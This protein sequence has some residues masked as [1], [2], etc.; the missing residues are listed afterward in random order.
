MKQL[1]TFFFLFSLIYNAIAAD[2][3]WRGGTG[4][5]NDLSMWEINV[6]GSGITPLN[7]PLS[8]DDVYFPASAFT[9]PNDT[10]YVNGPSN[11]HNMTWDAAIPSANAPVFIDV[12]TTPEG[13]T[14]LDIYGSLRLT[15]NMN[16]K[17]RGVLR[18]RSIASS[19]TIETK[20]HQFLL[21]RV[22]FDGG[23]TTEWILQDNFYLDDIHQS[24]TNWGWYWP[25][26]QGEVVL[27]R[28]IWNT[29]GMNVRLD[30]FYS[31]FSNADRGLNIQNSYIGLHG[32]SAGA[33]R[34]WEINFDYDL[35]N[36]SLFEASGS[37]LFFDQTNGAGQNITLGGGLA[38]DSLSS[39]NNVRLS[40][41][42]RQD[43]FS[44]MNVPYRTVFYLN[45]EVVDMH[46]TPGSIYQF[47]NALNRGKL[48]VTNLHLPTVCDKFTRVEGSDNYRGLI[49][50]K[51]PG[52]LTLNNCLMT[53]MDCDTVGGRNYIANNSIDQGA[54]HVGWVFNVLLGKSM[55]FRDYSGDQNWHNPN[56][57]ELWDGVNFQ[58]NSSGCVPSP[59]DDVFFDGASFPAVNKWVQVDSAAYCHNMRWL[60]SIPVGSAWRLNDDMNIYGTMQLHNN[61]Q[62]MIGN[63]IIYFYGLDPDSI[64][65]DNVTIPRAFLRKYS[66]YYLI[67][68]TTC[69]SHFTGFIHSTVHA[70]NIALT[71]QNLILANRY[72]DSTQVYIDDV[73]FAD[74]GGTADYT[75]T[76]T[77]HF[78]GSGTIVRAQRYYPHNNSVRLPN[79][80]AYNTTFLMEG[81]T[82]YIYG[83]L[84]VHQNMEVRT[85]GGGVD[86]IGSMPLYSG[87]VTLTAGKT[88]NIGNMYI[89]D[90]LVAI[91]DCNNQITIEP[92][93]NLAVGQLE[94]ADPTKAALEYCFVH[95]MNHV[96]STI[97]S[98]TSIDGGNLTNFAFTS[99]GAVTYYWRALSGSPTNF[100]GNWSNPNHWTTNPNDITGTAGGCIPT[101]KDSVIFDNLSF[102]STSNGCTIDK[103]SF[104]KTLVCKDDITLNGTDRLYVGES[105][106]LFNNMT[107][108]NFEGHIHFISGNSNNTL[109]PNNTTMPNLGLHFQNA[110]GTWNL[111]NDLVLS[112]GGNNRD[113]G[114]FI[115]N[116]T[117]NSNSYDITLESLSF[118]AI[119]G[120]INLDNSTINMLCNGAY[121]NYYGYVWSVLDTNKVQWNANNSTINFFNNTS[122]LTYNKDI[123]LGDGQQYNRV[124]F[125]ENNERTILHRDAI[126]NY[127]YFD[128]TTEIRGNNHFDSLRF[129]GGH[130][131][132]LSANKTQTLASGHGKIIANGSPGNFVYIETLPS[133]NTSYFHKEY[134]ESF[135][136]DFVK[137]KDNR[138]TKGTNPPASWATQ[139]PFLQFETGINSDN[140]NGTATGIW[141]FN[142]PP[143]LTITNSHPDSI[144]YCNSTQT[145]YLPMQLTGTYPYSIIYSW[146]DV[147]GG[148]GTDTVIVSDDDAN[149]TTIFN[150]ALPLHPTTTTSYTIDVGALRCGGRHYHA[151]ISTFKVNMPSPQTLVATDREANCYL[152]NSPQWVHFMDEVDEKPILSILDSTSIS[153]TDSLWN[154]TVG[155]DFDGTVQFWNGKPY[156]PRHWKIDATN[157]T[158]SGYVRLYFTQQE[159]DRLGLHTYN[160]LAPNIATELILWKF[161]DTITVGT[162]IQ[163]PFTVIPLSGSAAAPFSST[164]GIH[165]I[166]FQVSDFSGFLLQPNDIALLPLDLSHFEATPILNKTVQLT[167]EV[168]NKNNLDRFVIERSKDGI[169]FYE[170]GEVLANAPYLFTDLN[171]LNGVNYYRLRI[172][173]VDGNINYSPIRSAELKSTTLLKI[174]PNPV[175]QQ[176]MT[177]Q[178]TTTS[179]KDIQLKIIDAIGQTALQQK[180][181][182]QTGTTNNVRLNLSHLSQGVYTLQLV[183]QNGNLKHQQFIIK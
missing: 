38:Y 111:T 137:V 36:Y 180:L 76:T 134:G 25:E 70:D 173:D 37:H 75:G 1:L 124:N 155:V 177:I 132:Y 4:N 146:V 108:Y 123:F 57:W 143:I 77:F 48:T 72:M 174:T 160:G 10:I 169:S 19:E 163:I 93:V 71:C 83:D 59:I 139:H 138:A 112:H 60:S 82:S 170:V 12:A 26:R 53:N 49:Q 80:I 105:F 68:N 122:S 172:L 65:T 156:L 11:C 67:G 117:F 73:Y 126:F 157:T 101:L 140:I 183:D 136:L 9:S 94:L 176:E 178:I 62:H 87:K 6:A 130:Y 84:L 29:N 43:T 41:G 79:T 54:N 24:S 141:A 52:T 69:N 81:I 35:G 102:S 109:N 23:S 162:P 89:V 145:V 106:H 91:G 115:K 32:Y 125:Y 113:K 127:A 152:N 44:Y 149:V 142:L 30:F 3:Y 16:F 120:T 88:Y 58:P 78:R 110:N 148:S 166:E 99:G 182:L 159:L 119:Q 103:T 28:G 27:K 74:A 33:A 85:G 86:V 150:Y 151:P 114:F 8:S 47:I 161:D 92:L 135:C 144:E 20:G 17:F 90:S 63:K 96:G 7:L 131:Y 18:F 133:G 14:T 42:I 116:G 34:P 21:R 175:H 118:E 46:W 40:G 64:I 50:K 129:N 66:E 154:V 167:W 168:I 179:S 164:T 181:Q 100:V 158:A 55:F 104:C 98:T 13:N 2:F 31:G 165:A 39:N 15:A 171:P 128:G 147:L 22:E 95:D 5:Y 51:T 121:S 56:N 45:L 61:M 107:N 97:T 153:D